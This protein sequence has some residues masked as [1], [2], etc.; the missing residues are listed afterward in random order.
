MS[1]SSTLKRG[2]PLKHDNLSDS[3]ENVSG[4]DYSTTGG[5]LYSEDDSGNSSFSSSGPTEIQV[6]KEFIAPEKAIL[7]EGNEE[8]NKP[9]EIILVGT[10]HVSEKSVKEVNE[11][12]EREKPDIVA[13]ELCRPRFEAIKGNVK[14]S[15]IPVKE[16]LKEGKVYFYLVHM[17]LAHIQKKFADEMGVQPGAEMISAIKAAEASGAQILL[18]DRDIQVTLQRFWSKMGFIEKMKMLA[19]LIAAVLGLGGTKDIDMETITNQDMVSML[20]EEFRD[21]SP[22]AVKVLIDERDAYMANNLV[23]AAAGGNKKI[24]AVIGAGHRAGI[25]RYLENPKTIPQVSYAAEA[26][27]KRFSIMKLFGV[28]VVAIA[29]GTFA[30]LILSGVPLETLALAFA[31]W[32]IINGVLSAAGAIIARGH[33]YSV[34]TA[35]SV[36]WLTSLNPMMAAGWFAGLT[37][38][39]YRP[40]TTDNFKELIEIETTED[41]MKNNLFRVIMV[42]ALAN[43]GSMIGTFLGVYVMIQVTGID[44][45]ELIKNGIS[46]GLAVLGLG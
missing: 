16:L 24:V 15:E 36:A 6:I 29:L 43:L 5:N 19:G 10:A 42:A 45:Q 39:K 4:Y 46:A 18:I 22:N 21:S 44:P 32:F 20:V 13:V 33:P 41:M 7:G 26:P 28:L 40:P 38:A 9:T 11:A 17:L 31:W 25:Q 1:S 35:F 2:S 23:R 27:K 34:L 37:E 8:T 3:Q 12:I 30:L 14:N